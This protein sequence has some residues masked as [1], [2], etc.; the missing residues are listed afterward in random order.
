MEFFKMTRWFRVYD[1]IVDNPKVQQLSPKNFRALINLWAL[2]SQND[3]AL[4]SEKD[5]GFRLRMKPSEVV[6]MLADLRQ[7]EL[8]DETDQ[9]LTPHNWSSRQYKSDTSRERTRLYR[10]RKRDAQCDVTQ[11][12]TVTAPD[13]DT[14]SDTDSEKKEQ[15]AAAV[16]LTLIDGGKGDEPMSHDETDDS[17]RLWSDGVATLESLGVV[18]TRAKRMVGKWLK[19]TGDNHGQVLD[20]I[21][22]AGEKRTHDP[23][24]WITAALRTTAGPKKSAMQVGL[25][26]RF[27]QKFGA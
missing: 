25:E 13:T 7:A 19:D 14:D 15:P 6:K 4:P 9:G 3:G 5:I 16:R 1:D 26:Q 24:P 21:Y 12:V 10:Q 23:I 2:A 18:E 11:T 27:N 8:I 20:A 22:R 17:H